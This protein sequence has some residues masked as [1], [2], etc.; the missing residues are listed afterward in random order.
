MTAR[1]VAASAVVAAFVVSWSAAGAAALQD[2][3]PD[4]A[5]LADELGGLRA[6]ASNPDTALGTILRL[7]DILDGLDGLRD[8]DGGLPAIE[9]ELHRRA[10]EYRARAHVTREQT[11]L[12]ADDLRLL[13]LADPAHRLEVFG[14]TPAVL[15]LFEMQRSA[16]LAHLSVATEPPGATVFVGEQPVG[17]TPL[18]GHPVF[19]GPVRIRI[20]RPGF[21]PVEEGLRNLL[22]G[23]L[24]IL[25]HE[26]ERT[27]PVLPVVTAPPG[28]TV[29]VGGRVV[30]VTA[31][32]LPEALRPLVPPRFTGETFSAPLDLA[33]LVAGPNEITM[34]APCRR[35]SRFVFHADEVR[36][37]LPRFVR[38]G[39]ST[40]GLRVES[41]P[42][43]GVVILDGEERGVTPLSFSAM[44]SGPHRV[45][46]RHRVGR[47]AR[48][49]D[50][51]RG[52]RAA[53]RCE[54][55][56]AIL[57]ERSG[58]GDL[59][60]L[61]AALGEVLEESL[62]FHFLVGADEAGAQARVRVVAPEPGAGPARVEFL[63]AGSEA[64]DRAEFDRFSPPSAASALRELLDPPERRRNW[65]GLTAT[66]RRVAGTE[67]EARRLLVTG[68]H[69]GGPA[70]LAGVEPGDEVVELG[71][72]AIRDELGL[73]RAV[74]SGEPGA[75]VDLLV[76]RAASDR[77]LRV[78]VGETP[79]LPEARGGR[80]NRR[81]VALEGE[82][83]RGNPDPT[84][85]LEAAGCWILLGDPDRAMRDHLAELDSGPTRLFEAGV[86]RGTLLYQRGVALAALG[87]TLRA[88]EAFEAAAAVPGATLRTH[89]GPVL[90]PLAQRHASLA[91]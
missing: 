85:R 7:T 70:A 52:S 65:I 35:P 8:A 50:V 5:E 44:C 43:G 46:I 89:D 56:P 69:P 67:G 54:V 74:A 59:P 53:V 39:P 4:L 58:L 75:T 80:C 32:E 34:E 91:R 87:E 30:G 1:R 76:R 17:R 38:L 78:E 68:L 72:E 22:P 62:A 84:L 15:D 18:A 29:R 45:E 31:G 49:F 6:A 83:A 64:P 42:M 86:G 73:R 9:T 41:D 16:L 19:A 12:A 37:Y 79:V 77:L 66:V 28:A 40:G 51:I 27:G 3:G 55:L 24:V 33:V 25:E 21:A 48:S 2:A 82:L 81:L 60:G 26:L 11:D 47:C 88:N 13:V 20:E 61:E 14:L 90:A 36:D 57:L 23:D 63:V 10:L 71:G